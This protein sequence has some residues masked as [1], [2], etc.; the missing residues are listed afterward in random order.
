M[1]QI[2]LNDYVPALLLLS[3]NDP[4][5]KAIMSTVS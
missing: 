4:S 1:K 5:R 2:C 3:P